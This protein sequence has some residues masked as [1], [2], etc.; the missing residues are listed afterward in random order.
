M[1][2]ITTN[3][4]ISVMPGREEWTGRGIGISSPKSGP[5][6]G[7]TMRYGRARQ[8]AAETGRALQ[9]TIQGGAGGPVPQF[10]LQ[11]ERLLEDHLPPLDHRDGGTGELHVRDD[12][13]PVVVGEP[14]LLRGGLSRF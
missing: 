2:A 6:S 5:G 12:R 3:S 4:S 9:F 14:R 10:R 1:I 8:H 13:R 11:G 7:T